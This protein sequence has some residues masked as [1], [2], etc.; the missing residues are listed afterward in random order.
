[1]PIIAMGVVALIV[2]VVMGAMLFYAAYAETKTEHEIAHKQG[3]KPELKS[4]APT[5]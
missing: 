1:M 3:S 5:A 4:H 2:F